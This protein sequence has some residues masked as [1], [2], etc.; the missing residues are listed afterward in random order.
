[1]TG[2]MLVVEDDP[3]LRNTFTRVLRSLG[4]TVTAVGSVTEAKNAFQNGIF[5]VVMSDMMLP[6]GT[7]RDF[8]SWV[9]ENFPG[10]QHRFFFCSGSMSED[11]KEYVLLND[12]RLLAKPLDISAL[13]EAIGEKFDA[14]KTDRR[15]AHPDGVPS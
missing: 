13:I 2:D 9:A 6:D 4:L 11:L 15:L 7:G 3:V 10:H 5:S 14:Q 1:M 8:H 12:C